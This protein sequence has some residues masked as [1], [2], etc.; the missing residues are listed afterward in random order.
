M[1]L[2]IALTTYNR[3]ELTTKSI[4]NIIGDTRVKEVIINDDCS[5]DGSYEKL[6][7]FYLDNPKVSLFRNAANLGMQLN[8]VATIGLAETEWVA[9]LDSDNVF[10]SSFL[11]AFFAVQK[12]YPDTIYAPSWARPTFDYRDFEGMVINKRNVGELVGK[13][14]FGA[15]INTCNYIVNKDY[16]LS[17]FKRNDKIKGVDTANHFYNHIS[18]GGSFLVVP[19]MYYDHLVHSGSEFMKEVNYNMACAMEIEKQLKHL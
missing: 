17:K 10:D 1:E 7:E 19:N 18:T 6:Q 5:T 15:L 3:F 14:F 4:A 8:K 9:I 13:P 16:Y 11:D 2:T 12:H